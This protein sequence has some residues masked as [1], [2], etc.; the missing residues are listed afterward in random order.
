M[1]FTTIMSRWKFAEKAY[2][3][4]EYQMFPASNVC[5]KCCEPNE[6]DDVD[7]YLKAT[8]TKYSDAICN[9]HSHVHN[10]TKHQPADLFSISI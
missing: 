8:H 6:V 9:P 1:K 5:L 7:T 2:M 3:D 4:F 10:K